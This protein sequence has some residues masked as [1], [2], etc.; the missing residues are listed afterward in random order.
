MA[1][2]AVRAASRQLGASA[3]VLIGSCQLMAG[4]A[5]LAMPRHREG[6]WP[7]VEAYGEPWHE[8][9]AAL[10]FTGL[11]VIIGGVYYALVQRHK[12]GVLP[13][14]RRDG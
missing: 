14:H 8:R 7:R 12:T 2:P 10:L 13:E 6:A 11:L 9:Y 3:A 5:V 1:E 4:S